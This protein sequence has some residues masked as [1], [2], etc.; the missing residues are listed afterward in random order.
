MTYVRTSVA[1]GHP[2]A[3]ASG[4]PLTEVT[5]ACKD[6]VINSMAIKDIKCST[7]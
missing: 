2:F 3:R 7:V 4:V 5:D 6:P 1:G